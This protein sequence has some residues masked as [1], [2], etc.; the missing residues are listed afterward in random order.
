MATVRRTLAKNAPVLVFSALFSGT[1]Y[2]VFYAHYQQKTEKQNMRNG[3]I[4]D[5]KRDRMKQRELEQL[6]QQQ[7]EQQQ[8]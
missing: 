4:R 2:A 5:I 3:V 6:K 7:H 8:Q 1:A